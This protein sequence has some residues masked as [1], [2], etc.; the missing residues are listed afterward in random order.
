MLLKVQI[1]QGNILMLQIENNIRLVKK[2]TQTKLCKESNRMGLLIYVSNIRC[3]TKIKTRGKNPQTGLS[4][5]RELF[6]SVKTIPEL[7]FQIVFQKMA[8]HF[9]WQNRRVYLG[10]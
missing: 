5:N 4:E 10:S 7:W 1:K 2:I 6:I 9:T 3:R 8:G